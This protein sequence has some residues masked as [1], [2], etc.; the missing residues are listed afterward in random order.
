LELFWGYK[1]GVQLKRVWQKQDKQDN[2]EEDK[3]DKRIQ[4]I[5]YKEDKKDNLKQDK[6]ELELW[7]YGC[8]NCTPKEMAIVCELAV[9]I[10]IVWW[11]IMQCYANY[12]QK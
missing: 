11:V 3:E 9:V 10:S 5:Q 2:L 6:D 7:A 4:T 1:A 12:I 8:C